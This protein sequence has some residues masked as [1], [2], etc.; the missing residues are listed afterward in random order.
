[1]AQRLVVSRAIVGTAHRIQFERPSRDSNALEK[2][3]QQ[4]QDFR[5]TRG[6]FASGGRR[7]ENLG[8][9][10]EELAV[11]A[12]LR[13]LAAKLRSDV[14]ELVE[15]AIP[16]LVLDVSAHHAGGVFRAKCEGL[17]SVT[18]G[19]PAIFPCEHL[20]RNDVGLFA[21]AA[22]EQFGRFEDGGANLVKVVGPED[23][24]SRGFDKVP[25]RRIGREQ[26]TSSAWGFDHSWHSAI[27]VQWS[28]TVVT[29]PANV[30]P[31]EGRNLLLAG[32]PDASL[33]FGSEIST[34]AQRAA[35]SFQRFDDPRR[36][37][38]NLVLAQGTV[39]GL[40][41]TPEQHRVLPGRHRSSPENLGRDEALQLADVQFPDCLLNLFKNDFVPKDERKI[42]LHPRK[43]RQ[44]LVP[45]APQRARVKPV[46]INLGEIYILPQLPRLCDFRMQLSELRHRRSIHHRARRAP[47]VI[48]LIRARFELKRLVIESFEQRLHIAFDVEKSQRSQCLMNS[49]RSGA[50][51]R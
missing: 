32:A 22:G 20:F 7:T 21:D 44:R 42:A 45:N 40:K 49:R 39:L 16:K 10:L 23:I 13:A 3:C 38:R 35:Q 19:T 30:I 9:N 8:A 25:S 31:T 29:L 36:P 15:P 41:F 24:A 18:L 37:L 26:V 50:S 27:W 48:V 5:V 1:F 28:G 14:E 34:G 12:F 11:A 46:Q 51:R 47:R 33:G 17:A 2:R 6:R 43:S 4:F